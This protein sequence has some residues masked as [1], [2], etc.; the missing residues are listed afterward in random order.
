MEGATK[1]DAV[2]HNSF[3]EGFIVGYKLI[4]GISVG[5]PGVPMRSAKPFV[6]LKACSRGSVEVGFGGP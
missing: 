6:P 4:R 3:R 1:S 5:V 2:P